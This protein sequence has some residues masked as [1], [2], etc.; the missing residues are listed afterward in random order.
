MIDTASLPA[1][2]PHVY[3]N[4]HFCA[5]PR[6]PEWHH[7]R[8]R[9]GQAGHGGFAGSFKLMEPKFHLSMDMAA[10][11]ALRVVWKQHACRSSR[12]AEM[13]SCRMQVKNTRRRA[14]A[15]GYRLWSRLGH[16]P[17][18][19]AQPRPFQMP[20]ERQSLLEPPALYKCRR[21]ALL[22]IL[23]LQLPLAC[24]RSSLCCKFVPRAIPSPPRFSRHALLVDPRP[25]ADRSPPT[26]GSLI[27]QSHAPHLT[28]WLSA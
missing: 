16:Q 6:A 22:P 20:R 24:T 28:H 12:S 4:S 18:P 3:W 27:N 25:T 10:R 1:G 19:V 13:V 5:T 21:S 9:F 23:T 17:G 11:D 7:P 2:Q 26:S 8:L 14:W 15:Q